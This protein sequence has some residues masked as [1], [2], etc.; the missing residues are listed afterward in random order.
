MTKYNLPYACR[1]S[2]IKFDLK[3]L[4]QALIPFLEEFTDI[5]QAN[6]GLCFNHEELASLV[7]DHFFQ[8]SLTTCSSFSG[9]GKAEY[10]TIKHRRTETYRLAISRRKDYPE[11]DE[12]NWNIP[13][14]KFKDSYFYECVRQF[15]VPAIRVRLTTLNPG[16]KI[17]PHIDYNVDYATRIMVPIYTNKKCFN[18]FW[19]KGQQMKLHIPADGHPWFLNV[20]LKHAVENLGVSSRIVLM[21]S[22]AG[23]EDIQHLFANNIRYNEA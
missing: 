13:T 11:L 9:R 22:L 18:L 2:Y 4:R 21:F 6:K 14:Q 1:L 17:T 19:V 12:Y 3:K 8:V 23:T 20:A 10:E 15:K 5:Y 7:K 16:A